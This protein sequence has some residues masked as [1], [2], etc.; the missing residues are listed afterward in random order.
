MK[1]EIRGQ[2]STL[3][4]TCPLIYIPHSLFNNSMKVDACPVPSTSL[5]LVKH[6]LANPV[7]GVGKATCVKNIGPV[8][9]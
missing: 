9:F 1:S 6:D 2:V 7:K 4:E 5:P 3:V 8:P